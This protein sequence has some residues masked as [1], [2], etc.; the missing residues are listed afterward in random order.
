MFQIWNSVNRESLSAMYWIMS[1]RLHRLDLEWLLKQ[2][3]SALTNF[4]LDIQ[5]AILLPG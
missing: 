5:D 2:I 3:P 1:L 4:A